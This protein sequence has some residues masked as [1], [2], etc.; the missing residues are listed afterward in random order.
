MQVK[1]YSR[2]NLAE[3]LSNKYTP[4]EVIESKNHFIYLKDYFESKDI[5]IKTIVIEEEY[6]SKDYLDDYTSYYSL[7][8]EHYP[9]F[10]KR[11]HFFKGT[12]TNEEFKD[13]VLKDEYKNKNFWKHY[14][15]FI[16]VKPIPLKIIGYSV[17]RTYKNG[18][19]YED[20]KFWGVRKYK[21]NF[22]GNEIEFDSLAFQEQDSVLAACATTAIWTM[23]NKASIDFHTILK[24]PSQITQDAGRI[25]ADGSRLFPNKGLDILQICQAILNSGLVTEVKQPDYKEFDKKG[26]LVKEFI[27]NSYFKK[28]LNAYSPIGI[29]IIVIISVPN[30]NNYGLHAITVSGFKQKKQKIIVPKNE[31]SWLSENIEKVY[32]HDDQWGPFVRI[33]FEGEIEIKTPWTIFH[34]QLLPTYIN[35]IIVPLFP[36]IR[37]SYEDIEVIVL[38]LD[39]IL[40][41]FFDNNIISDLVWD[42]KIEYSERYKKFIKNSDLSNEVKL[43]RLKRNLPKY[44]WIAKCSIG[45]YLILEFTFDATDV[46]TGMIGKDLISF[47]PKDIQSELKKHLII[48]QDL[49]KIL[50][51]YGA[52]NNYYK[53]LIENL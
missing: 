47:L 6:V 46:V 49:F 15:G 28:I 21:I 26:R 42:I 50:F 48:N 40:T 20:R 11:V 34:S 17:L 23:L 30:D 8:F 35:N 37:I 45:E 25:S 22:Y 36:K 3:A 19:D 38:G 9:K 10:C 51:Q 33:E 4:P 27:S 13:I 12:F 1:P 41:T 29:P 44:L 39:A 31:I 14:M 52:G 2:N 24:S 43:S 32:V 18:I 7:C 16:V 5:D 53:F